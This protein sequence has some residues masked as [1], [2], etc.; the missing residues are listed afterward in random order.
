MEKDLE[1]EDG[2]FFCMK[3]GAPEEEVTGGDCKEPGGLI[4]D[5]LVF[6]EEDVSV[7]VLLKECLPR[8]PCGGVPV[9]ANPAKGGEGWEEVPV[10]GEPSAEIA[11]GSTGDWHKPG[12]GDEEGEAFRDWE[13]VGVE[14]C[15]KQ[16]GGDS[17]Q[18]GGGVDPLGFGVKGEMETGKGRCRGS[19]RVEKRGGEQ[20]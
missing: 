19:K 20:E 18:D 9:E 2:Y 5:K 6:E 15:E 4:L 3:P 12:G 8:A 1:T 11:L 13:K 14:D 7:Q 10:P 16:S 17:E